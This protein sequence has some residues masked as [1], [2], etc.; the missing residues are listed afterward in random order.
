MKSHLANKDTEIYD[1]QVNIAYTEKSMED[2]QRRANTAD[3]KLDVMQEGWDQD[4]KTLADYRQKYCD[5]KMECQ[6]L[7]RQ[8]ESLQVQL[9]RSRSLNTLRG[10]PK[11]TKNGGESSSSR[12]NND[13]DSTRTPA[14]RDLEGDAS[15]QKQ[16]VN[17]K[18]ENEADGQAMKEVCVLE[19]NEEGSCKRKK[20]NFSHN[21]NPDMR[22]ERWK[23]N[24]LREISLKI[25]K[26][27]FMVV[28]SCDQ[29]E[30]CQFGHQDKENKYRDRGSSLT[31]KHQKEKPVCYSELGDPGSCKRGPERCRFSHDITPEMRENEQYKE[32][33]QEEKT[34]KRSICV[35]EFKKMGSCKNN[36]NQKCSFR[37]E[38]S[39]EE[40]KDPEL[41]EKVEKTWKKMRKDEPSKADH[42]DMT[43]KILT[44][45]ME[46]L[47]SKNSSIPRP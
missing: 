36:K 22:E 2:A 40:G 39:E 37:H 23:N 12:S 45:L 5:K 9:E 25:G 42:E 43:N 26:C 30:D 17:G 35:N 20:C 32:K 41:Q 47:Q 11:V 4:R 28:K 27:M 6:T 15:D 21:I 1:L 7:G 8:N 13:P 19:L 24:K 46:L 16:N 29:G 14:N 34:R 31:S 10:P 3:A 44:M 38:I 33:M 18:K